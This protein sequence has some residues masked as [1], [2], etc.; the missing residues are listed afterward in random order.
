MDR[1]E[2][3]QIIISLGAFVVTGIGWFFT[4]RKQEKLEKELLRLRRDHE[5]A[6]RELA[7]FRERIDDLLDEVILS[8]K[9][10]ANEFKEISKLAKNNFSE[11]VAKQHLS[12]VNNALDIID[13]LMTKPAFL[14]LWS[15]LS[16][17][18]SGHLYKGILELKVKSADYLK[19]YGHIP[20]DATERNKL[21]D[22]MAADAEEFAEMLD[23]YAMLLSGAFGE[24]EILMSTNPTPDQPLS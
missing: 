24:I 2:F 1:F 3:A 8:Y 18:Q 5:V 6:D 9:V 11:E 22:E 15:K 19:R 16:K 21:F 13:R 20:D 17:T 14:W 12:E 7:V 23:V 4:H 10:A